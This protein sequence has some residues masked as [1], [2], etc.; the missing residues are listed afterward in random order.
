[1]S[2]VD[3]TKSLIPSFYGCDGGNPKY[4]IWFC[5]IEH[6]GDFDKN[7]QEITEAFEANK[8]FE[9][10]SSWATNEEYEDAI[11]ATGNL[12]RYICAF[13]AYYAELANL[14]STVS[15]DQN[16]VDN[17]K[18]LCADGIGFKMN[19]FPFRKK[20]LGSNSQSEFDKLIDG[21]YLEEVL[22]TRRDFFL[23]QIQE[24]QTKLIICFGISR[25]YEFYEFFAKDP[26][27]N[28]PNTRFIT[29]KNNTGIEKNVRCYEF[30][31]VE[32][33]KILVVPFLGRPAGFN[34]YNEIFEFSKII[35][36]QDLG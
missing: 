24:N 28:S 30:E 12:N 32:N 18:I 36:S 8:K 35:A 21:N 16:F 6:G 17:N 34:G 31:S 26:Q 14:D 9:T 7:K 4:P 11:Y 20:T 2:K 33:C 13:Y 27:E 25:I 1:M 19:L 3:Y 15:F 22:S 23:K 29:V 5:G 10:P